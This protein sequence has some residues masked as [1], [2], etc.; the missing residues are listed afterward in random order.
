M[1]SGEERLRRIGHMDNAIH[2]EVPTLRILFLKDHGSA[3]K[4]HNL[5]GESDEI[6]ISFNGT[7][8]KRKIFFEK[9]E[10]N[11]FL[12]KWWQIK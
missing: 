6:T 12:Y 3:Y 10:V 5:K 4:G 1:G 9:M 11:A 2:M 7:V 8:S